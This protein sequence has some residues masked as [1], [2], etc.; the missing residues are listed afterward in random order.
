MGLMKPVTSLKP[1]SEMNKRGFGILMGEVRSIIFTI[2]LGLG[3]WFI[4]SSAKDV[5]A[6]HGFTSIQSLGIGVLIVA[7][8][9]FIVK[10]RN[11]AFKF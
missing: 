1:V 9:L 6:E 3:L 5:V 7:F 2:V 10:F 4:Y 8:V 11:V